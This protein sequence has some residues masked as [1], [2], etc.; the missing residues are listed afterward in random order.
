MLRC[1]PESVI[2]VEASVST[3]E[4]DHSVQSAEEE[5]VVTS[6]PSEEQPECSSDDTAVVENNTSFLV[7]ELTVKLRKSLTLEDEPLNGSFTAVRQTAVEPDLESDCAKTSSVEHPAD[8]TSTFFDC[9]NKSFDENVLPDNVVDPTEE[10]IA[11]TQPSAEPEVDVLKPQSVAVTDTEPDPGSTEVAG[12]MADN[13]EQPASP[14]IAVTKGSYAIN[15][16]DFDEYSD[17]FKPKKGLSNSPPKSPVVPACIGAGDG[18]YRDDVD[19][20]KPSRR[21]TNSPP[22]SVSASESSAEKPTQRRSINNNLP[23]PVTDGIVP[24]P[25]NGV[26]QTDETETFVSVVAE[27][28]T[29]SVDDGE[30]AEAVEVKSTTECLDTVK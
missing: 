21:L 1:R 7:D 4:T 5:Q 12:N 15:W 23:E 30:S 2:A 24:S 8:D 29:A 3:V 27:N 25:A 18:N 9:E 13:L 14:P 19:P 6:Q 10:D 28:K 11:D 20:F 26:T 17:P 16:D 22:G